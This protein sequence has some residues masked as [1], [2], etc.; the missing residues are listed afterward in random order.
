MRQAEYAFRHWSPTPKDPASQ[1]SVIHTGSTSLSLS[2]LFVL[3]HFSSSIPCSCPAYHCT[4]TLTL[5][6]AVPVGIALLFEATSNFSSL[7]LFVLLFWWKY[8]TAGNC[9]NSL[10]RLSLQSWISRGLS[11]P[12]GDLSIGHLQSAILKVCAFVLHEMFP[13]RVWPNT[14]NGKLESGITND[15]EHKKLKR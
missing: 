15:L 7:E 5:S 12:Q 14:A 8:F 13:G 1:A 9:S 3:Q 6:S 11:H 10:I 4:F 2:C